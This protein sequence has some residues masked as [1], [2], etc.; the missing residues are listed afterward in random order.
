MISQIVARKNL[1]EQQIKLE[2]RIPEAGIRPQPG[3]YMILRMN[4]GEAG[5]TLPVVSVDSSRETL[6]V[7]AS[8]LPERFAGLLNP[9]V[10]GNQVD[11]AGPYGQ[12]FRIE[13]YDSVLCVLDRECLIPAYSVLSALRKAGNQV[14]TL[15]TEPAGAE[16]VVENEIRNL[17]DDLITGTHSIRQTIERIRINRKINQVIVIG[18]APTIRDTWSAFRSGHELV[19]AILFLNDQNQ[20]GLHGIFRVSVCGSSRSICVDGPNFNAYYADFEELIR[21]FDN[22]RTSIAIQSKEK[23]SIQA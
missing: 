18:S 12:A 16:S 13:K 19:Q 5:I 11:L 7:I 6:T 17:S 14:T 23:L 8:S 2:I 3:Q 4:A 15:L 10:F 20:K 9:C 21:R 22:C 1:S